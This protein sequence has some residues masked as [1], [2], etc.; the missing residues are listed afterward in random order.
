ML[1][2]ELVQGGSQFCIKLILIFDNAFDCCVHYKKKI[3]KNGKNNQL[4]SHI[5]QPFSETQA[6]MHEH[7]HSV[8]YISSAFRGL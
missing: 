4:Q 8:Y 5:W 7:L 2:Q 3:I 1:L 6:Q